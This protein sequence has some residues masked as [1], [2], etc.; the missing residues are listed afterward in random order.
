MNRQH[1]LKLKLERYQP[2]SLNLE[3]HAQSRA[4]GRA[5]EYERGRRRW[6]SWA[7]WSRQR[8][9]Q[10]CRGRSWYGPRWWRSEVGC[11]LVL[12]LSPGALSAE[13]A[14]RCTGIALAFLDR[15]AVLR[16][17][18]Q[19]RGMTST[20]QTARTDTGVT[21]FVQCGYPCLVSTADQHAIVHPV[22]PMATPP[23]LS[24]C[25]YY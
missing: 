21:D 19:T 2:I 11:L 13:R 12:L 14:V 9:L 5:V 22:R 4:L 25:I 15:V 17:C 24:V 23:S 7:K 18:W 3:H 10:K 16:W 8:V 20:T 1:R 6:R